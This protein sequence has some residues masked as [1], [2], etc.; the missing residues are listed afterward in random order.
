MRVLVGI[1]SAPEYFGRRN[2]IRN[3]WMKG[4]VNNIACYFLLRGN[5]WNYKNE[6]DSIF[7]PQINI[8]ENRTRGPILVLYEWFKLCKSLSFDFFTKTDDDVWLNVGMLKSLL[9]E[10]ESPKTT[11]FYIG[12]IGYTSITH[13]N[14]L[15]AFGYTCHHAFSVNHRNT[16]AYG[17]YPFA[18][19]FLFALSY[20]LLLNFEAENPYLKKYRLKNCCLEDIWVGKYIHKCKNVTIV[21]VRNMIDLWGLKV[22]PR[23]LLWHNKLKKINRIATVHGWMNSKTDIL[24]NKTCTYKRTECGEYMYCATKVETIPLINI[25]YSLSE[26]FKV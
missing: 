12:K 25:K 21:D 24:W 16:H 23:M 20:R 2:V 26:K 4:C 8:K 17:P 19:G 14:M 7:F 11:M 9:M 15:N 5:P 13:D 6:S 22:H 10:F 1:L 18:S 3:T